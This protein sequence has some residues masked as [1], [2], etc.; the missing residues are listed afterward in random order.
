MTAHCQ[1]SC[2]R[3]EGVSFGLRAS[4]GH[5]TLVQG[6]CAHCALTLGANVD[7]QIQRLLAQRLQALCLLEIRL[8]WAKSRSLS[9]VALREQV[10]TSAEQT[11]TKG[12]LLLTGLLSLGCQSRVLLGQSVV[13]RLHLRVSC[14]KTSRTAWALACRTHGQAATAC[15]E[16][17]VL[18]LRELTLTAGGQQVLL[19]GHVLLCGLLWRLGEVLLAETEQ[20]LRC[21]LQWRELLLRLLGLCQ[22]AACQTQKAVLHGRQLWVERVAGPSHTPL[23][24]SLE[25]RLAETCRD[26]DRAE[27]RF[28]GCDTRRFN[29]CL[30]LGLR[31]F[32]GRTSAEQTT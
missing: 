4:G 10:S 31:G 20:P 28:F 26:A 30:R 23:W 8:I 1:C 15:V 32:F 17:L 29:L 5:A 16:Q 12:H 18:K 14:A 3:I 9:T 25:L 13:V 19:P 24:A 21:A 6:I 27:P 7:A 22:T 11:R 2:K